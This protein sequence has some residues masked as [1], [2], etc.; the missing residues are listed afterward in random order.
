MKFS[1]KSFQKKHDWGTFQ[2]NKDS[3]VFERWYPAEVSKSYYRSG[4]ILNDTTFVITESY[5]LRNGKK[6]EWRE[7]NEVYHF[8]AFSPKP[9]STNRFIK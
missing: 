5:R 6:K 8:K 3:I 1:K 4:K 9:D 2:I 7:K